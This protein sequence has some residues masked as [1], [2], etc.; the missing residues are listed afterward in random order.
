LRK[1]YSRTEK[2]AQTGQKSNRWEK[3][4][5]RTWRREVVNLSKEKL[6]KPWGKKIGKK[7]KERTSKGASLDSKGRG[8]AEASS[9][10]LP[11]QPSAI[12]DKKGGKEVCR[13]PKGKKGA[14]LAARI[15][16]L[17]RATRMQAG[18]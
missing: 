11:L 14:L 3:K 16:Y 9:E 17:E 18:G 7:R 4:N 2:R 8:T 12:Y 6:S 10:C 15:S 1:P 13:F 5:P